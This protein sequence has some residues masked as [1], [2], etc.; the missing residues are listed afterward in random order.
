[1]RKAAFLL[2]LVLLLSL[3]SG[4]KTNCNPSEAIRYI[5][6]GVDPESWV[7]V[8]A[9]SFCMGQFCKRVE[10]N[11]DYEIMAT[12]VTNSQYARY[13]NEAL[14]KG[15]IKL[16]GSRILGYYPGDKYYGH[17]HERKIGEGYWLHMDLSAPGVRIKYSNGSFTVQ[18]GYENHPVTMVTWFGAKAYCEFYGWRLPTEAEWEKAARG[19][20]ERAYPWGDHI[21]KHYTNYRENNKELRKLLGTRCPTTTPVGFFN[22]KTYDGF[23]TVDARSPYGAYDMAGNVWEWVADVHPKM[24]DRFMKGGSWRNYSYNLR[25]WA[26][27]SAG[28]DYYGA[29]V[30]FRCLRTPSR[31]ER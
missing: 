14:Q 24:H 25:I 20:D 11:Y 19:T 7:L 2:A 1:M 22:G 26:R 18:K 12:P 23:K 3:L 27:N 31:V 17:R 8:P 10:I 9:G 5:D 4:C 21:D 16:E 6:T 30:G 15:S 28:P 13:L 29:H